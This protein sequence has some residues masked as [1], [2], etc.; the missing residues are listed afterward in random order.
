MKKIRISECRDKLYTLGRTFTTKDGDL[1]CNWTCSGIRFAF[2]GSSLAV[3]IRAFPSQ[4]Q[5][6]NP[7]TAVYESRDTWPW[8]A[9]FVDDGEEPVRY[10][11]ANREEDVYPLVIF[12][13]E[14]VHT[15]TIRKMTENAKG[16]ICLTDFC[17]DGEILNPDDADDR[18]RKATAEGSQPEAGRNKER[19][20]RLEFVG[21]S[22]TCGFGNMVNDENRMFYSADENGWMAHPA[23][24]ARKLQADFSVISCSGIAVTEGIGKFAYALPPMKYYYP[25]C[26]RMVQELEGEI[27]DPELW[28]FRHHVPDVII[29]NLG[30][31]DATVIDLNGDTQ[32]GIDKF[33]KDYFAFLEMLREYNGRYSWIICA[34]GSLDYFLYDNIQKVVEKFR[35]EYSDSRISCFKYGRVR[36]NDGLG[37]C[38]HPY[39]TT[40]IRMGEEL[41]EYIRK[42]V[43]VAL[44]QEKE[45]LDEAGVEFADTDSNIRQG[46][47]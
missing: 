19:K 9:V 39:V 34:L 17:T 36:V 10:F 5:E 47:K 16:K 23:V 29:L 1:F 45:R 3:R 4:E 15:V 41:A 6:L 35:R 43:R 22:I 11:E 2:R 46:E 13:G 40:Q 18:E 12:A 7:M 21:D 14:E 25:Y 37:A 24:A 44:Y 30:T 31:N 33:E 38:R 32:A 26:D 8:I 42:E 28:D 20:L 27:A